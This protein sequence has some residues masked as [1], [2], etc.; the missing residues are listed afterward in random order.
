MLT[1]AIS[2]RASIFRVQL[3]IQE[4]Q[5]HANRKNKTLKTNHINEVEI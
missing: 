5:K 1:L 4:P 2:I 3:F